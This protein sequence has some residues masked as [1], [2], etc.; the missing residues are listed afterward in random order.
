MKRK[1]SVVP[2]IAIVKEFNG[3]DLGD[4]RLDRRAEAIAEKVAKRPSASFPKLMVTSKEQEAFYRFLRNNKV[5]L[6]TALKTGCRYEV[7]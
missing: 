2:S 5:T 3:V 6:F 4:R 7:R 1:E